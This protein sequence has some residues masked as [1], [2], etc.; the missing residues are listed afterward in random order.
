MADA[1]IQYLKPQT[2]LT[3]GARWA[4]WW[5]RCAT[6]ASRRGASDISEFAI[7]NVREDI[8]P[9][10]RVG[11]DY[12]NAGPEGRYDLVACIEVLEHLTPEEAVRA[13]A[14][15]AAVSDA[16]LFSSTPSDF[17]EPTHINVR[18]P[19]DWLKLFAAQGFSPDLGL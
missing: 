13:I 5:K 2:A 15:M 17:S 1:L 9:Y 12:A 19:I 4:F 14:N 11:I 18:P 10:C 16:I 7:Q 6:G 8:R 3:P